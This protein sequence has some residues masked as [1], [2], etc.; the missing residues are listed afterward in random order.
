MSLLLIGM[1]DSDDP[2]PDYRAGEIH[3]HRNGNF[4]IP[5]E[6]TSTSTSFDNC[7]DDRMIGDG[8]DRDG[9]ILVLDYGSA[10]SRRA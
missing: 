4:R 2:D 9:E 10:E 7:K 6:S 8:L 3:R 5:P 1:S